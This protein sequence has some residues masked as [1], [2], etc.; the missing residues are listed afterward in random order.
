[1]V[2]RGGAR[3]CFHTWAV[4]ICSVPV[5]IFPRGHFVFTLYFCEA[6]A[7]TGLPLT[8]LRHSCA[9][10]VLH[11]WDNDSNNNEMKRL[12]DIWPDEH[13]SQ[14]MDTSHKNCKVYKID[15]R[16]IKKRDLLTSNLDILR[17][18]YKQTDTPYIP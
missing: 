14:T 18:C 3:W 13:I 15:S 5:C 8:P 12:V 2:H 16:Q 9:A 7:L 4:L 17:S 11:S 10:R 1:M 6:D